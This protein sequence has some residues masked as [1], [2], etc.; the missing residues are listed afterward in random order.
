M[1]YK[2]KIS[3]QT[4]E[5]EIEGSEDWGRTIVRD[6]NDRLFRTR[7]EYQFKGH[8][9]LYNLLYNHLSVNGVCEPLTARVYFNTG[10]DWDYEWR[11]EIL[12]QDFTFD[13]IRRNADGQILDNSWSSAFNNSQDQKVFLRTDLSKNGIGIGT[14]EYTACQFFDPQDPVLGNYLPD[15][16]ITFRIRDVFAFLVAYLTDDTVTFASD[17]FSEGGDGFQYCITSGQEIRQYTG[18]VNPE[19]SFSEVFENMNKLCNLWIIIEGTQ[20][21][22]ILRI[23]PFDYIFDNAKLIDVQDPEKIELGTDLD[24]LYTTIKVGASGTTDF[25]GADAPYPNPRFFAWTQEEYNTNGACQFENNELDLSTAWR[26]DHNSIEKIIQDNTYTDYDEDIFVVEIDGAPDYDAFKFTTDYTGSGTAYY[27]YNYNL[28]NEQVVLRWFDGIPQ[29][30]TKELS[31]QFRARVSRNA[32]Q[33]PGTF[34]GIGYVEYNDDTT[35]PNIDEDDIY[36][37][38]SFYFEAPVSGFYTFSGLMDGQNFSIVA[39]QFPR[40]IV[41]TYTDNTLGTEISTIYGD[42]I[43]FNSPMSITFTYELVVYMDAGNAA[44]VGVV[45]WDIFND[46]QE[47]DAGMSFYSSCYCVCE[48]NDIDYNPAGAKDPLIYTYECERFPLTRTEFDTLD[49]G[50]GFVRIIDTNGNK[51]YDVYATELRYNSTSG[52]AET[53][54]FIGRRPPIELCWIFAT[55]SWDDD[56]YW[57]D[58]RIVP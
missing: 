24:Q 40:A 13:L 1:P 25:D 35:S 56:C 23:E 37:T 27:I 52:Y 46:Q 9:A 8:V 30:I 4:F 11:G 16:R 15:T 7:G 26:I 53:A 34:G 55:G 17:Y 49:Q 58:N 2:V 21:A 6:F 39:P 36:N 10:T 28:T 12:P 19:L 5:S 47:V 48:T 41:T 29:E 54:K 42:T 22:P 31:L 45:F 44:Q 57:I 32:L 50:T 43:Q 38:T 33:S 20:D 14:C 3:G 51:Q 18:W